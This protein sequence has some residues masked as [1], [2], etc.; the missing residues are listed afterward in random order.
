MCVDKNHL[1]QHL[2]V[3]DWGAVLGILGRTRGIPKWMMYDLMDMVVVLTA[4]E[5]G[6]PYEEL[7]ETAHGD[8]ASEL[9]SLMTGVEFHNGT[10]SS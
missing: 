2:S 4:E 10:L 1:T 5:M 3:S 6:V 8:C 9:Q 7:T